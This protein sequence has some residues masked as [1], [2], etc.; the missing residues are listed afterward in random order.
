MNMRN[1]YGTVSKAYRWFIV[2]RVGGSDTKLELSFKVAYMKNP[3]QYTLESNS[4][5]RKAR[6]L[7]K[8]FYYA[9][10]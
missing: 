7:A 5:D 10:R 3:I 1:E 8:D 4:C 2:R 6:K 9:H